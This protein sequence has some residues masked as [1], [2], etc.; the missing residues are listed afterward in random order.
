VSQ[1]LIRQAKN[2]SVPLQEALLRSAISRAYYAAFGKARRHL[3]KYERRPEPPGNM[4]FNEF[5]ERINIHQYVRDCFKNRDDEIYQEIG[6]NLERL[7]KLRN[8]ADYELN[9]SAIKNL[10]I[11][12]QVSLKWAKH[13]LTSLHK[14]QKDK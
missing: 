6:E 11:S 7:S 5:G 4:L 1:E 10:P 9:H 13:I 12:M 14:L 3:V 8:I 2:S